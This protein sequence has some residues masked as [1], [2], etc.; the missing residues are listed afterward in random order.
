MQIKEINRKNVFLFGIIAVALVLLILVFVKS[1]S[2]KPTVQENSEKLAKN[3]LKNGENISKDIISSVSG[4]KTNSSSFTDLFSGTGWIDQE[5]TTL[6]HDQN[7]TSFIFPPK[8]KWRKSNLSDFTFNHRCL[9]SFCLV[10]KGFKLFFA[11]KIDFQNGNLTDYKINLPQSVNKEILSNISIG[12]LN[13]VWV[14]GVV[15][16]QNNNYTGKAY[17]FDGKGFS[18]VLVDGKSNIFQSQHE[19]IIGA[20]GERDDFIIIYGAYDGIAYRIKKEEVENIS[21]FFG[22][23][24]MRG[25]F[26]PVVF[27]KSIE[28]KEVWYVS[29]LTKDNPQLIKLFEDG[30]GKIAGGVD[31]IPLLYINN[32]TVKFS[33]GNGKKLL[34]KFESG[35]I[36]EF[37][38]EGFDKSQT[39]KV[40][41]SNINNYPFK[42][43]KAKIFGMDISY[44]GTESVNFYLSSNGNDWHEVEPREEFVFPKKGNSVFWKAEAEP[45]GDS[46]SSI[47]FNSVRL[48][49]T[50]QHF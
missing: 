16:K 31:F 38:D 17:F 37:V 8:Y 32:G 42:V 15:E 27:E 3:T 49:Y 33:P 11:P 19:G 48:N 20:G 36:R 23:R 1:F 18:E 28:D 43:L 26:Y 4:Q 22:I 25:G 39:R 14:L 29:S 6:Y 46:Y 5:K 34:A 40:V 7:I 12:T 24:V 21:K 2:I 30:K 47:F 45:D 44:S 13:D 9:G 50:V 41:S 10:E 35:E